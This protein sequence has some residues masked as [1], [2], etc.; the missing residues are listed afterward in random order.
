MLRPS[1]FYSLPLEFDAPIH[2]Q[3][4]KGL[5]F[6][7]NPR[8]N[9]KARCLLDTKAAFATPS[10]PLWLGY[11]LHECHLPHHDVYSAAPRETPTPPL[12]SQRHPLQPRQTV[13]SVLDRAQPKAGLILGWCSQC[14][15]PGVRVQ[16]SGA[17]PPETVHLPVSV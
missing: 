2:L 8:N 1:P 6:Q 11:R 5:C 13:F 3:L 16:R 12:A 17:E 7:N 10:A 14:T 4:L 9:C 15:A